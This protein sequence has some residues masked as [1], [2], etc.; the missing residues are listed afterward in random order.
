MSFHSPRFLVSKIGCT[1]SSA[2]RGD[3]DGALCC[4]VRL[5]GRQLGSLR[6]SNEPPKAGGIKEI[7]NAAVA[8]N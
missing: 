6:A 8:S 5:G 7:N 3:A 2:W 4:A 1:H